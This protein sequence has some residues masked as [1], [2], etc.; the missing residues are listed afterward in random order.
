MDDTE[1]LARARA[2]AT[3]AGRLNEHL[4][5]VVGYVDR[6]E[7]ELLERAET[8]EA[9]ADFLMAHNGARQVAALEVRCATLEAEIAEAQ[10]IVKLAREWGQAIANLEAARKKNDDEQK[11]KGGD[12]VK[13]A[14][15]MYTA[16]QLAL[17]THLGLKAALTPEEEP[18]IT[19]P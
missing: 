6:R 5:F 9:D 19:E 8:A 15:A 7:A 1:R 16:A 11:K 12:S 13:T 4:A 3:G 14:N 17:K 2:I 10:T 18:A